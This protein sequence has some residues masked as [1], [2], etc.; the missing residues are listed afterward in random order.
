M[1]FIFQWNCLFKKVVIIQVS[2]R[3]TGSSMTRIGWPSLC[4]SCSLLERSCSSDVPVYKSMLPSYF[5]RQTP[6]CLYF[7]CLIF[8]VFTS[9]K[10]TVKHVSDPLNLV[11]EMCIYPM[12]HR[13]CEVMIPCW[14]LPLFIFEIIV[15]RGTFHSLCL[16][17]GWDLLFSFSVSVCFAIVFPLFLLKLKIK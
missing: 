7:S 13:S 15:P 8:K 1:N 14:R 17:L 3:L 11:L 10:N 12:C 2:R 16:S 4:G 9:P 6:Q 5:I